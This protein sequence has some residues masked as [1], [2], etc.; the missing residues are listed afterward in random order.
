MML[1][2]RKIS[3]LIFLSFFLLSC[4]SNSKI[5]TIFREDDLL[6]HPPAKRCAE[7]HQEIY[8]QWNKSRHAVSYISE[9][10]KKATNHYAKT[11]CLACHIP[12]EMSIAEKPEIREI[13]R[14]DGINCVS[15][16]FSSKDKAMHGPYDVF[17]PPHPSMQ[18]KN[19]KKSI[20]CSSCH[21]ETYKQ[22]EKSNISKTCQECHMKPVKK[23]DLIQKFPF[24]LFHLAKKVYNHS[25]PTTI[26]KQ[27][28]LHLTAKKTEDSLII[29]LENISIP[30][31]L[32]TADN[33]NPKFYVLATTYKN[34]EKKENFTEVITP[35]YALEYKKPKKIEFITFEDFDKVNIKVL[36]KLS[37]KKQKELI[38]SVNIK[39]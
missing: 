1:T 29:I 8:K 22:W 37:W 39:F 36:R 17:S 35:K 6:E 20:V 11:K 33:G 19:F 16:H 7:C 32:P 21:Q 24:D 34:G 13:H 9:D 25:F 12:L 26:A 38:K 2:K 4:D 10:Y 18:D 23:M 28:D 3:L 15:C 30:H 31:N 5:W 14:E 27:E